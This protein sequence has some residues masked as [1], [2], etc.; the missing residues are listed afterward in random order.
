MFINRERNTS[1]Q[2]L[3][4]FKLVAQHLSHG[5]NRKFYLGVDVSQHLL[6]S[7]LCI[8][9]VANRLNSFQYVHFEGVTS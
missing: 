8:G 3:V 2:I 5:M 6:N 1:L 4:S 9:D 7:F